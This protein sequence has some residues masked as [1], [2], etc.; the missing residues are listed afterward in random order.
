MKNV[1]KKLEVRFQL[2]N[3]N[4]DKLKKLAEK[5]EM[6]ISAFTKLQILNMIIDNE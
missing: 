5:M 6:S 3:D 1:D 2:S 4:Y